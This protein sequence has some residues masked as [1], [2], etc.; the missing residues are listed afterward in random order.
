LRRIAVERI[1]DR[2]EGLIWSG[3]VHLRCVRDLDLSYADAVTDSRRR[4]ARSFGTVADRY[5]RF[6][7][8]YSDDAVVW[9]L[10]ERPLRVADLGAGTGILSRLLLRLGHEVIAIEPDSRM[11]ARLAQAS[12]GVIAVGGTA[13]EI[14]LPDGSVDAVVAGQAYHWFDTERAHAEVARVLRSGGVFAALRNDADLLVPWTVRLV[15]VIDGPEALSNARERLSFG[16]LFGSVA[17]AEFRHEMWLTLD[18]LLALTTTRS[19]YLV[20]TGQGR[21][22][23]LDAVRRLAAEAALPAR[24][25][26]PMP[27]VTRVHRATVSQVTGS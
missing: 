12:R 17:V 11:R 6:R 5:D 20:A 3:V 16:G 14:P 22:D 27:H 4:Q 13:E 24:E 2:Y 23:L 9:A 7:P 15:E 1:A 25:R 19:P 18:D 10:G 21:Q 26:F 8:T